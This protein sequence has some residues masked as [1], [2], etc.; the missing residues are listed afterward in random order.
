MCL[1]RE[2]DGGSVH[3]VSNDEEPNVPN[4]VEPS[5]NW[6][7]PVLICVFLVLIAVA[8]VLVIVHK[9]NQRRSVRNRRRVP[10]RGASGEG[11][12]APRQSSN[13]VEHTTIP[14][15]IAETNEP[16]TLVVSETL[17]GEGGL[18]Q[19]VS[20]GKLHGQG[21][22]AQQQDAFGV[23]DVGMFETHGQL[24]V[25]ADGMGGLN[26]S[27]EV[28]IVV[29]ET[30]LQ[31]FLLVPPDADAPNELLSLA[32]QANQAVNAL[33][34]PQGLKTSGS[35]LV[36]ALVRNGY[37]SF[38]SI[39]DSRICLYRGGML[40]QLNREHVY[41]H[42]LVLKAINGEMSLY[43]A[44]TDEERSGLVSYLGMG[45]I[46]DVDAPASPLWLNPGDI[47]LLMTDGVYNALTTSEITQAMEEEDPEAIV[48]KIGMMI[49]A[50]DFE[51]Q[52]NFTAVIMRCNA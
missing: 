14:H 41:E 50:K 52:D 10:A 32:T 28:S 16:T 12:P 26:N 2:G 8:A 39:G 19:S 42:D 5:P 51:N 46:K 40:M 44:L 9:R 31:N 35:T 48:A 43:D 49:E 33:L 25:V 7:I 24:A 13:R 4:K 15:D 27:D 38:L 23:S 18:I 30:I 29:V 1:S 22:R 47:V 45:E 3:T 21:A 37:L 36:M 11:R 17:D 34:G 20:L 6:V